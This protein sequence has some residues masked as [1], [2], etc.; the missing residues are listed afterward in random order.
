MAA[1]IVRKVVYGAT[2]AMAAVILLNA[3]NLFHI[4]GSYWKH[5]G[6]LTIAGGH[7]EAM[8]LSLNYWEQTANALREP[9]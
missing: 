6:N 5:H 2:I 1:S 7:R 8:F 4:R 9:S 3:T